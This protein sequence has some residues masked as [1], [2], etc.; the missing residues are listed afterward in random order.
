MIVYD[1][2]ESR[3]DERRYEK[4]DGKRGVDFFLEI[5]KSLKQKKIITIIT[6]I[7]AIP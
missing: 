5:N 6:I 4:D 3:V 2:H 1:T 7:T